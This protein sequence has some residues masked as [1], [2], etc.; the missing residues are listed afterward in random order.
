MRPEASVRP[1]MLHVRFLP[2]LDRLDLIDEY[3]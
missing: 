2:E 3:K 1:E